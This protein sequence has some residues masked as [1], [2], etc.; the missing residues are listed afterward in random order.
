VYKFN[1][2]LSSNSGDYEMTNCNFRDNR[3][4]WLFLAKY[5]GKYWTDLDQIFRF[6]RHVGGDD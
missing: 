6:S 2:I 1:D 5:L 4:I 3:R